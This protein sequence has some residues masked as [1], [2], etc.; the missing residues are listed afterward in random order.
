M[1]EY[2]SILL[3]KYWKMFPINYSTLNRQKKKG[4]YRQFLMSKVQGFFHAVPN[5]KENK[6]LPELPVVCNAKIFSYLR[7]RDLRK[8]MHVCNIKLGLEISNIPAIYSSGR[9]YYLLEKNCCS[10]SLKQRF[11]LMP[12]SY[13]IYNSLVYRHTLH[14]S[15]I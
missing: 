7:N 9:C 3:D 4:L 11:S 15:I 8:L 5:V 14:L 1:K 13:D 10:N 2:K 6:G 12:Y